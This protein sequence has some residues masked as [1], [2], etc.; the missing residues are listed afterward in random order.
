VKLEQKGTSNRKVHLFVQWF[1]TPAL[2]ALLLLCCLSLSVV[3]LSSS[4][5]KC[6]GAGR[7]PPSPGACETRGRHASGWPPSS[8][9]SSTAGRWRW[10]RRTAQTSPRS[11]FPGI[12]RT[13]GHPARMASL[14]PARRAGNHSVSTFI[15]LEFMHFCTSALSFF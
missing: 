9:R 13:A 8:T 15:P 12:H 14:P 5:R 7:P 4:G 11:E 6:D 3:P 1:A 10:R 2:P